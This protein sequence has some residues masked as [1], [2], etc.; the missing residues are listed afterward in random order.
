[1]HLYIA[2]GEVRRDVVLMIAVGAIARLEM[3]IAE[4]LCAAPLVVS[5]QII[6]SRLALVA[7]F[8]LDFFFATALSVSWIAVGIV[9][10]EH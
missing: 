7:L 2:R 6:M 4:A 3:T 5:V 10:G 1:M 8:A 9:V